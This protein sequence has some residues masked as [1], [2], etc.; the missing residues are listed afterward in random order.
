MVLN[1][2]ARA[3][4][5]AIASELLSFFD[6]MTLNNIEPT[7]VQNYF[8][9]SQLDGHVLNTLSQE[10]NLV[11]IIWQAWKKQLSQENI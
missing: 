1:L 11:T 10:A 2:F 7:N 3:N 5:W 8:S 4:P 6:A 9:Q